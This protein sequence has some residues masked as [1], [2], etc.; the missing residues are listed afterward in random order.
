[1]LVD[2]FGITDND[3]RSRNNGAFRWACGNGHLETAQ[4]LAK[5]FNLT[6]KDL[7]AGYN[8]ALV[9]ACERKHPEVRDWII[10]HFGITEDNFVQVLLL[11][12]DEVSL[13]RKDEYEQEYDRYL[14]QYL[15][16]YFQ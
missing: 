1:M 12:R 16:F 3:A 5:R 15:G 9:W 11:F 7:R 2:Y 6:I 10:Q 8:Q 14:T 4:W 13:S